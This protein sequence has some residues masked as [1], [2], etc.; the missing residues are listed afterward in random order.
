METTRGGRAA[1]HHLRPFTIRLKDRAL[2][3]SAVQPAR[4]KISPGSKTTGFAILREDDGGQQ[5]AVLHTAE[6]QH[7]TNVRRPPSPAMMARM[8]D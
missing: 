4:L 3:E 6:L 1:V 2:E 5:A 7:K 8:P